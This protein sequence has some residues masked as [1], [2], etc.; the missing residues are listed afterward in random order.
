MCCSAP[1]SWRT[2][3]E[4]AHI[5]AGNTYENAKGF[6][7]TPGG[8]TGVNQAAC[9][10]FAFKD[11]KTGALLCGI[12]LAQFC[13]EQKRYDYQQLSRLRRGEIAEYE[14]LIA[15]RT[16]E[17]TFE[18]PKTDEPADVPPQTLDFEND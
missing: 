9:K 18:A 5:K 3:L 17:I 10:P 16:P 12:N 15:L 14:D 8:E 11:K 4:I 7:L 1:K 6:N 13:R 2:R